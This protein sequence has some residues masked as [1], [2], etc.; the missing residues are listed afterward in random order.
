VTPRTVRTPDGVALHV[1]DQGA[2]E[3]AMLLCN[4]L[5]CS[6]HYYGPWIEQFARDH[7]VVSFDYRGHGKSQDPR[8]PECV[9]LPRLVDDA[10][11]VLDTIA[12]PTILVGHSMGVRVVL[13]LAQR[14]REKI[15]GV[16]LL[17]GS[18]FDIGDGL[19]ARAVGKLAPPLLRVLGKTAPLSRAVRDAV[20]HPSWLIGA[21]TLV[22]GLAKST[23][24]APIESLVRNVR[25]L[26]VRLMASIAR[27]YIEHTALPLLGRL[28]V[29]TLQIVGALDQLASPAH[30][31]VVHAQ[32][33]RCTTHVVEG[34]T[35]LAPIERPDEVHAVARRYLDGLG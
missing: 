6:T 18:A 4:G 27:S 21:G 31:R 28:D 2:G 25:R 3:R 17:C 23:P 15:R 24:R 19:Q 10:E 5:Y 11:A 26:D 7:R 30:A 9:T 13:E 1:E 35:H 16:I 20:V 33:P 8:D 29:P 32:I 34:C 22:G 14:A 12:E